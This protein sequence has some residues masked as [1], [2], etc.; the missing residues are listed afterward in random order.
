MRRGRDSNSRGPCGPSGFQDRRTRPLCDP[1]RSL[2]SRSSIAK[3][4]RLG[5]TLAMAQALEWE[6]DEYEF[7]AKDGRWFRNVTLAV[8][9]LVLLALLLKNILFAIVLV[10]GGFA[11]LIHGAKMPE[12]LKYALTAKGA[13][14]GAQL[15]PYDR[16]HSFW[17]SDERRRRQVIIQIQRVVLAD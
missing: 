15:F 14:I 9:A 6:A 3:A 8:G 10:V 5:Y 11:L 17:V 7:F 12:R 1:S 16:L 2:F 13:R 4:K